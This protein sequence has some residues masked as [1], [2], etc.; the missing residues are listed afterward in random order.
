MLCYNITNGK[1]MTSDTTGFESHD[2]GRCIATA[3]R[4]A[5][6]IC[7]DKKLRLTPIRRE[8]FSILLEA[9]E[10]MGAYDILQRLDG[11]APPVA[12]R[13]LGF[14]TEHGFVHRIERL[15]AYVACAH[16]GAAHEPAFMIC[17]SCSTVAEA[18]SYTPMTKT[19]AA[20]GFEIE[21]TVVEAEGLCPSCQTQ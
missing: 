15:N 9:H 8:V 6:R 14:L 17:R 4:E 12:Y 10:A 3:L 1:R 18:K 2:H 13:A 21:R 5:D 16:P 20:A 7:R 19:A 11:A